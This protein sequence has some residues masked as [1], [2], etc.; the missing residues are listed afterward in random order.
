M[1]GSA[2]FVSIAVL[3]IRKKAFEMRLEELAERKRKRRPGRALTFSLSRRR[4][5][6][7]GTQHEQDVAAGV[8]RGR[9]I[10]EDETSSASALE[11]SPNFE[12][13]LNESS[14][15]QPSPLDTNL[16][17]TVSKSSSVGGRQGRDVGDRDENS[18]SK[19]NDRIRF[20]DEPRPSKDVASSTRDPVS[21]VLQRRHTRLIEGSGVGARGTAQHPRNA[22]PMQ[23]LANTGVPFRDRAAEEKDYKHRA[24]SF[25]GLGID[26]YLKTIDGYIG[27]NSQFHNL[28]VEERRKLGGIEYDAICLLSWIIPIYFVLWQLLGALGLG[29]WL[30]IN[31]PDT[32]LSNGMWSCDISCKAPC[33]DL[34]R[35]ESILDRCLLR[36]QCLQQLG[37]GIAGCQHG[38]VADQLLLSADDVPPYSGWQYCVPT[39]SP[40]NPMDHEESNWRDPSV[41]KNSEMEKNHLVHPGPSPKSLHEPLSGHTDMVAGLF[42]GLSEWHRLG[43][44]RS[45]QHWQSNDRCH[46]YQIPCTGRPLP[47]LCRSCRRILCRQH[48]RSAFW[49]FGPVCPDDV[50]FCSPSEYDNK[51]Y[52][53]LRRTLARHLRRG[54]RK[55]RARSNP[56]GAIQRH[57]RQY[58]ACPD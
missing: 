28:T 35:V 46:T 32:A 51:K 50:H 43:L 42:P 24:G 4:G 25:A 58:Q 17:S 45:P 37:H 53:R 30:Q 19:T 18:M 39:F 40:A 16:A 57:E 48:L 47:G 36:H 38:G 2:I 20:G 27:R 10:K 14:T 7:S 26:K 34:G 29:A 9:V 52:E 55:A 22:R 33:T 3:H 15:K 44:I 31:R 1:M 49:S 8:V 11:E 6:A 56:G 54:P 13:R 23:P 21:P 12:G 41:D 5:S